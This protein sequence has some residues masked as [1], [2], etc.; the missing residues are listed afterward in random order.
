MF[1]F[2]VVESPER[3]ALCLTYFLL[4]TF[5]PVA[6]EAEKLSNTVG[7]SMDLG[8]VV[9]QGGEACQTPQHSAMS[10]KDY[11]LREGV[12]EADQLSQR[13]KPALNHHNLFFE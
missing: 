9:G 3:K 10:L 1:F 7:A 8:T 12:K 11:I 6:A 5:T 4:E 2:V 13:P